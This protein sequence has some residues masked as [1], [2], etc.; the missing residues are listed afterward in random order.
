MAGRQPISNGG[1]IM[2]K[3]WGMVLPALALTLAFAGTAAAGA[4]LDRIQKKGELVVGVSGDQPPL[5]ATSREGKIIGLEAD[6]ASR[7]ASAMGVNLKLAKMPFSELLQALSSG[8]VDMI[9][10]GM[11]MTS[12]RNMKVAFVGPYYVTG[13]AVL[14]KEATIASTKDADGINKPEYVVTALK[15][16]T[17][18]AFIEKEMPKAKFVPVKNY[19]EALDLIL[20]DKAHAMVA[21]YHYCAVSAARF[22]DKGLTTVAAPFTYEPIGVAVPDGDPLMVNWVQNFLFT[23]NGSGELKKMADRWFKDASWLKELP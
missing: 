6:I 5:N 16:S 11:T 23:L 13:K 9:L 15:G 12:A 17:S 3:S 4:V 14:T 22:R 19:E 10:S 18:Q 8:N 2:K 7:M 1:G 20:Q 21:D